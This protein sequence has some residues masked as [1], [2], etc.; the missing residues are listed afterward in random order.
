MSYCFHGIEGKLAFAASVHHGRSLSQGKTSR[1]VDVTLRS[2]SVREGVVAMQ[3]RDFVKTMTAVGTGLLVRPG[4]L[5]AQ[6]A[7]QAQPDPEVNRVLVMFKCHFDAGFIDT[8]YNVVHKYFNQ[9]F[10]Q[11]IEVARAANAR[12][13]RRYVWTTGSW[14][15]FEYLEQAL[16]ADRK[17]MEG[18]IARGDIAWHALPFSWQSEMLSPSMIEGSLALSQSLDR[19]FGKLTTG[20]KM[21]DVPGHTRGIIAPLANHG[22]TFLEIG[23][24]GGSTAAELPPIFLWKDPGGASL[25]M[26]YHHGYGATA[27]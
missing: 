3:R 24:N 18:A 10:P 15:L 16:A 9:Y 20:A 27:R 14:L 4:K 21:T 6:S 13:K 1:A 11:A 25:P 22:V 2:V 8:Q 7:P 23:V 12:G 19:R 5:L 26:M 17:T